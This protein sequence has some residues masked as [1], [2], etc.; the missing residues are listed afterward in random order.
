MVETSELLYSLPGLL[1]EDTLIIAASQSG[2]SAEIVSLLGRK[3]AGFT[4][5]GVTNT[6]GSPLD[7]LSDACVFTSAGEETTVSCKTYLATLA[8][9]A[10]L[11]PV[12]IGA[13]PEKVLREIEEAIPALEAYLAGIEEHVVA[14]KARLGGVRNVF[15][16]GRGAS[17][18]A[19]GT[20]GLIIK[21]AAHFHAEGMS[22]A[23][24]RHGP[25]EMLSLGVFVLVYEGQGFAVELNRRLYTDINTQGG[26][27]GLV[28]RISPE[29]VFRLPA[30]APSAEPLLE[31]L[32]AQMMTL[33]LASLTGREAGKFTLATKVT[34]T[35]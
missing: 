21:E 12:L 4:V 23:A 13:S 22:S 24:F 16:A 15:V 9:L 17:L 1:R 6:P 3:Q 34:T 8:A 26:R 2:R 33:A 28:S 31:I 18:A 11:Q 25:L 32:P 14:L 29:A 30:V 19:V 27:A 35:E 5:L 7:T 20:G 10:W